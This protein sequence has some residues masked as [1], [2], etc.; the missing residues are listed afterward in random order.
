MLASPY[1][2]DELQNPYRE[3]H[4]EIITDLLEGEELK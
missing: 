3:M 4:P 2:I 1:V